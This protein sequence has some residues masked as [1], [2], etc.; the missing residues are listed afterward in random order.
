MNQQTFSHGLLYSVA[1]RDLSELHLNDEVGVDE[2][3]WGDDAFPLLS[4]L[5]L[6][7]INALWQAITSHWHKH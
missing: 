2:F 7:Y 6:E 3:Y 1:P 5:C 4:A